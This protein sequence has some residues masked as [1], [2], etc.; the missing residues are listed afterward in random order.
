M[1]ERKKPI[2][3]LIREYGEIAFERELHRALL[4]LGSEFTRWQ[5]GELSSMRLSAMIQDFADGPAR[6]LLLKYGTSNPQAGL[7]SAIA[8]GLMKKDEVPTE[9]L[10]HLARMIEFY[11]TQEQTSE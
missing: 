4:G 9:L 8:S 2:K 5:A 3:K 7:A 11:E 1:P 10:E 6:D